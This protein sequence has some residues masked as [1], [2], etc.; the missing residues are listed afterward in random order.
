MTTPLAD[1][2]VIVRGWPAPFRVRRSQRARRAS[3]QIHP[4]RGIEVV[5]PAGASDRVVPRLLRDQAAWLDRHADDV[6]RARQATALRDGASLPV[7]GEWPRLHIRRALAPKVRLAD[8]RIHIDAPNPRDE[9][10]V[11]AQLV[12]WYRSLARRIVRDRVAV[13]TLPQDGSVRRITIRDQDTCWG[14]CTEAGSLNFNWRL[15]M[16]PPRVLDAVVTHELVHLRILDHSPAFW[17]ALDARSAD[18]RRCRTW[19]DANAYR[20]GL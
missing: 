19:L 2:S 6:H 4:R 18:H 10:A 17:R 5:L 8:G 15:V 9:E 3:L 7:R 16:A 11:R 1:G 12:R 14:S 13:L 20:L